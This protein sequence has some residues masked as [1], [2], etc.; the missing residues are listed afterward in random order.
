[1]YEGSDAIGQVGINGITH[2][3][4]GRKGRRQFVTDYD[5]HRAE[6]PSGQET[7]SPNLDAHLF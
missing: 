5:A 1:M 6:D 7:G 3:R 4:T 2:M